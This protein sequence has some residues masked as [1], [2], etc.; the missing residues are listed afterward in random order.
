MERKTKIQFKG[1]LREA[2]LIPVRSAQEQWNE[3]LLEDETILRMK[4]IV[5]EVYRIDGMYT[6]DGD[7]VYHIKSSTIA[8]AIT[9]E[10]LKKPQGGE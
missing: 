3:Y 4:L 10:A 1:Q 6:A 5:A 2:T 9:P 7:P 8:S